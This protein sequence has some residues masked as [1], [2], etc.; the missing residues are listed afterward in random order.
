[1]NCGIL[2]QQKLSVDGLI[3]SAYV[4]NYCFVVSTLGSISNY[5]FVVSMLGSISNYYC[6]YAGIVQSP[7]WMGL[8]KWD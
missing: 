7:V 6:Q 1:M 8:M 3:F 4:S 2:S 5:C